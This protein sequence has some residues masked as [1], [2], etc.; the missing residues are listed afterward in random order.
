MKTLMYHFPV[1]LFAGLFTAAVCAAVFSAPVQAERVHSGGYGAVYGSTYHY[2][3]SPQHVKAARGEKAVAVISA[4]AL[5]VAAAKI[6]ESQH[7]HCRPCPPPPPCPPCW[8]YRP[9]YHRYPIDYHH[10]HHGW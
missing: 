4:V 6:A 8:D 9:Q 7:R 2:D 10:H 1:R 3:S 5:A